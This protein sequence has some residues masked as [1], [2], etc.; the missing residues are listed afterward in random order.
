[1]AEDKKDIKKN[2]RQFIIS[3][4]GFLVLS[5]I[6]FF[7]FGRFL[8][9][10]SYDF[11]TSKIGGIE[12][13]P[14][15]DIQLVLID[16][17]SLMYGEKKLGLGRWP[18]GRNIYSNILE[19]MHLEGEPKSILFDIIFSEVDRTAGNDEI[20]QQGV[21]AS[22]KVFQ[23]I[24]LTYDDERKEINPLPKDLKSLFAVSIEN[25]ENIGFKKVEVNDYTIPLPC[26][27]LYVECGTSEQILKEYPVDN[28]EKIAKELAVASFYPDSDGYYRR[29]RM[30]FN[31]N[32]NYFLSFSLAAVMSFSEK[33][34]TIK[35]IDKQKIQIG[36]LEVPV[37][38][39][40]SYLV[41]FYPE[42]RILEKSFSMSSILE[43]AIYY[44]QGKPNEMKVKPKD[45]A[46]KIV[47]I[48][49]SAVGCQDLKTTPIA[50]KMPG[51]EIHATLISNILQQNHITQ[52]SNTVNIIIVLILVTL[53]LFFVI[54][55]H[56]QM[57][58]VGLPVVIFLVTFGISV[59]AFKTGN[60]FVPFYLYIAIAF[61][62]T[63]T[64]FGYRSITEGKEKRKYSKI[65]GNMI[66][67]TIVK[68]AL[69]DLESL[70]AGSEKEVTPFFS[71]VAGFSSISEKLTATDLAALLNEY[72]SAMTLIL[73]KYGGTLDKYIGD[74]VVGIFGAPV[75]IE[76]H[77]LKAAQASL[78]M[79]DSLDSLRKEWI[80]R[81]AYCEEARAMHFRIGLNTGM[82]K[83]GFMG[84]DE[85][86]SYT[87]MGDTVNLA[88][89]LEAAA[90][91]YGVH[92]LISETTAKRIENDMS[93][94][95]LD[96]VRVKGKKEGVKIYEL[97][98]VKGQGAAWRIKSAK[99]YE[100]G[101]NYYLDKQWSKAIGSLKK[102]LE[103]RNREDEAADI[104][105]ERC[106]YYSLNPP[107]DNWDG[108][109]TRTKK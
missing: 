54:M 27:R 38:K 89:R 30:L 70:K 19:F 37:E 76:N 87:M 81:K 105:I 96:Q 6:L 60:L 69:A 17:N 101:F 23:N 79:I 64:A 18:W 51:P 8:T 3:L 33:N 32:E 56:N 85:L 52:V 80:K 16:E 72:L 7:I 58:Q 9:N 13:T 15:P 99:I 82:A 100:E 22:G 71:D 57:I 66:D 46:N 61:I 88:A 65:L 91:D 42:N 77:P 50:A 109:F 102:S 20:F 31:Y 74:A 44:A 67:P 90:K 49:C 107:P 47:I 75:D 4:F 5:V 48:G 11:L 94:R 21:A 39:D 108:V 83:V 68:E 93:T 104:L 26:L 84:T 28:L 106:E 10:Q 40:G 92:I 2:A 103:I 97:L 73:K 41:N 95:L 53:C 36:D 29:G 43:S 24:L 63:G 14:H 45:F 98:S 55:A 86:A 62:T 25:S 59:V 12:K 34:K 1:L 35:I 78:A